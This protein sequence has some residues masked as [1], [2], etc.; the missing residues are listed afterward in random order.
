MKQLNPRDFPNIIFDLGG[1]IL[2]IDYGLTLKG[3]SDLGIQ[4][5]EAQFTQLKQTPL[6]DD[7]ETGRIDTDQFRNGLREHIP[8]VVSDDQ[9]D[10]AWNCMLL[11]LPES[12]LKLLN[13][14]KIRHR[15]FLLSNTNELHIQEFH[16]RLSMWFGVKDLSHLFE[17][18][19][20]SFQ[21]GMRKPD[22]E[23]FETVLDQNRLFASET[24][25]IDDSPQHIEGAKQLGIQAHFLE[26]G[27]GILDLFDQ[28]FS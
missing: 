1:V 23:I 18:V 21:M 15:I 26:E 14:L 7:Y 25:F 20:Y 2:N 10:A 9:I 5:P 12:R 27:K 13:E 16:R 19:Y 3:F 11:D 22:A 28:G 8:A 4:D 24:L 17:T 6:F